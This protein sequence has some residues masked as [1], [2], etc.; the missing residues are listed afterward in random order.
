MNKRLRKKKLKQKRNDYIELPLDK[1]QDIELL[2]SGKLD[3]EERRKILKER[4]GKCFY[5]EI[6]FEASEEKY[7]DSLEMV[8]EK[9]ENDN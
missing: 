2:E 4:L 7:N 9:L 6:N 1:L 3:G 8:K 5:P